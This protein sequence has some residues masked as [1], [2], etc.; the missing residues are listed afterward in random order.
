[1]LDSLTASRTEISALPGSSTTSECQPASA[2]TMAANGSR[3]RSNGSPRAMDTTETLS[4]T[5][6]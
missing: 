4:I 1:M 2:L 3:A 5:G 6:R